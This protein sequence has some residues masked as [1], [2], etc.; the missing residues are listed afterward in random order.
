MYKQLI[1][2]ICL[3]G[4]IWGLSVLGIDLYFSVDSAAMLLPFFAV[5][6]CFRIWEQ[7]PLFRLITSPFM[8]FFWILATMACSL[9]EGRVSANVLIYGINPFMY[10]LTAICGIIACVAI[11]RCG[12][13]RPN[14]FVTTI[15]SG[16]ILIIGY[17]LILLS[18]IKYHFANMGFSGKLLTSI[19]VVSIFYF[20]IIWAY[21]Y[22]P[23]LVGKIS[24][25]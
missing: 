6:Q 25:R 13:F 10:Y 23:C 11:S 22:L 12:Y 7:L 5:G 19:I 16:T 18:P 8:S 20:P 3:A 21:K 9:Y 15:S 2:S 17:H 24:K 4:F 1:V 14:K